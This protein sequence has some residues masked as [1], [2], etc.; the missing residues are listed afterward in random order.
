MSKEGPVSA[1]ERLAGAAAAQ[2][3]CRQVLR[4]YTAG[5][6]AQSTRA[7]VNLRKI[8]E[9]YLHG[10]Y[11]LEVFDLLQDPGKALEDQ[12]IAAPTTIRISPGPV[13]RLIGDLSDT[14]RVLKSLDLGPPAYAAVQPVPE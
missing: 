10:H 5:P 8:C 2:A 1:F 6:T 11:E 13:R 14:A 3:S 12:I 7:L 4:L 9:E